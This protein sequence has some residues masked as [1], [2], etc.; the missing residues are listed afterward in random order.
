MLVRLGCW[1]AQV[2]IPAPASYLSG[3]RCRGKERPSAWRLQALALWQSAG[4]GIWAVKP[5]TSSKHS[6]L[7]KC[8]DTA[9]AGDH[10]WLSVDWVSVVV[11]L[12]IFWGN[13][14]PK[15]VFPCYLMR[16]AHWPP[17]LLFLLLPTPTYLVFRHTNCPQM[18]F[19][20]IFLSKHHC[21][22]CRRRF[23][24]LLC[25]RYLASSY[26]C[27]D[28][29]NHEWRCFEELEW[30]HSCCSDSPREV[31]LTNLHSQVMIHQFYGFPQWFTQVRNDL[32]HHR[33][34][35]APRV[36]LTA[37]YA[38]RGFLL[39][40]SS[41]FLHWLKIHLNTCSPIGCP[42]DG[43]RAGAAEHEY[44]LLLLACA[45]GVLT[46]PRVQVSDRQ[47]CCVNTTKLPKLGL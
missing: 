27:S 16:T 30:E 36:S 28:G 43:E 40:V 21:R 4:L 39:A 42:N 32:C 15:E 19:A 41:C 9:R 24:W 2:E 45:K 34:P 6:W 37:T 23:W 1:M 8:P 35:H 18:G 44:E 47:F 7:A 22:R 29:T 25:W 12:C 26:C 31:A 38:F 10:V 46:F 17:L 20:L 14:T 5:K 33:Q 11:N 3:R 13:T